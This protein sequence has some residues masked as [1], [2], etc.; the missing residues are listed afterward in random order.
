MSDL[1]VGIESHELSNALDAV[2]NLVY[3]IRLDPSN[4]AKVTE[5]AAMTEIQLQR[6]VRLHLDTAV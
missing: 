3:L 5:W 4:T 1:K 2:I 6:M